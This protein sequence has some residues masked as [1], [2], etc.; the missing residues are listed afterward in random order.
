MISD[1]AFVNETPLNNTDEVA[2]NTDEV[3]MNNPIQVNSDI[4]NNNDEII[5][6][7]LDKNIIV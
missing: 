5:I 4:K 2:V 6:D 1:L 3:V 7:I